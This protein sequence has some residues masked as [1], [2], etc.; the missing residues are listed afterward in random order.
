MPKSLFTPF[1]GKK[2]CHKWTR[3]S[4]GNLGGARMPPIP[5]PL[6]LRRPPSPAATFRKLLDCTTS[7]WEA[8]VRLWPSAHW[9]ANPGW[10]PAPSASIPAIMRSFLRLGFTADSKH[11]CWYCHH[12]TNEAFILEWLSE[13]GESK[14]CR[15]RWSKILWLG[16]GAIQSSLAENGFPRRLESDISPGI[17]I[18]AKLQQTLDWN[19]ES[20]T[21]ELGTLQI[22]RRSGFTTMVL[23]NVTTH[24]TN[25]H[26]RMVKPNPS[27]KCQKIGDKVTFLNFRNG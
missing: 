9:S 12:L 25:E 18:P 8:D 26:K 15:N 21:H 14:I 10:A 5:V 22:V 23:M 4:T 3:Q 11:L 17:P 6:A 13:V 27:S 2:V 16:F 19:L 24:D 1:P 7:S 20:K